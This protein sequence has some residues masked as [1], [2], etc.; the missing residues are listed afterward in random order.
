M[1]RARWSILAFL[2]GCGISLAQGA[3]EDCNSDEIDKKLV[4][5]SRLI[6]QGNLNPPNLAI[7]YSR[8]SDAHL[9]AGEIALSTSDRAKAVELDPGNVVHKQRLS[10][11]HELRGDLDR[12]KGSYVTAV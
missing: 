1:Q 11:L 9:E 7:A 5:C 4:G 2:A 12:G 6:A 10:E 3:A 8:R